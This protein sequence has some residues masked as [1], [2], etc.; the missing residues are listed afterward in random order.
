MLLACGIAPEVA[1]TSVRFTFG[2]EPLAGDDPEPFVPTPFQS[3]VPRSDS[4]H[5]IGRNFAHAYI[6]TRRVARMHKIFTEEI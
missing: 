4:G 1:Q 3:T 6:R 5:R 2:R